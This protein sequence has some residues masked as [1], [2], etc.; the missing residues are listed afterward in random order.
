MEIQRVLVQHVH[1]TTAPQREPQNRGRA[2][3]TRFAG[4][5][6]NTSALNASV[7]PRVGEQTGSYSVVSGYDLSLDLQTSFEG[8]WTGKIQRL[9]FTLAVAISE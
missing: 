6:C 3:C 1:R 2:C 9:R 8:A 5:L 4:T 7:T